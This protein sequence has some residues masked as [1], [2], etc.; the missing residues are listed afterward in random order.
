MES[1]R[2]MRKVSCRAWARAMIYGATALWAIACTSGDGGDGGSTECER[3][4]ERC[5][6]LDGSCLTGLTCLSDVC[7]RDMGGA[8]GTQGGSAGASTGGNPQGG[9]GADSTGGTSA[10]GGLGAMAGAGGSAGASG[11]SGGTG[12][13]AGASGA[14]GSAGMCSADT[15]V[16]PMNCGRCGHVCRITEYNLS[17]TAPFDCPPPGMVNM[18]C[19]A[20]E[21]VP[22]FAG[23]IQEADGFANCDAYCQSIGQT[24]VERGC[25]DNERTWSGFTDLDACQADLVEDS[26][27]PGPCT[28]AID[29]AN[30]SSEAVRCCCTD[31]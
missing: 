14:G 8:G 6:C 18:C 28:E 12:G 4:T 24:C 3:G 26:G 11:G 7:V 23:C 30:P 2:A 1:F 25:F 19:A 15:Q 27:S 13:S 21:C 5:A 17:H 31:I 22:F 9:S 16:D 10:D 29:F 20:G